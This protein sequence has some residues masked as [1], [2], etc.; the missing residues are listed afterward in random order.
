[1]RKIL[2]LFVAIVAASASALEFGGGKRQIAKPEGD[3]EEEGLVEVKVNP[4][5]PDYYIQ[6][7]DPEEK[8]GLRNDRD[9]GAGCRACCNNPDCYCG[10]YY[11]Y[12]TYTSYCSKSNKR[13]R[14]KYG[15]DDDWWRSQYTTYCSCYTGKSGKTKG[16]DS[17]DAYYE[18]YGKS[19]KTKGGRNNR[20]ASVESR[21]GTRQLAEALAEAIDAEE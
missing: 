17:C 1:M 5:N 6:F 13:C 11:G 14:R 21:D 3:L 15:D 12:S 18:A 10:Y 2:A 7:L 8:P 4:N 9:L 16:G 20:D 19:G